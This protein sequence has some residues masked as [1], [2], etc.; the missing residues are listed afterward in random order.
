MG[1][2]GGL[3]HKTGVFQLSDH[4]RV[5]SVVH[6]HV[7]VCRYCTWPTSLT[8]KRATTKKDPRDGG[9]LAPNIP[10]RPH[11]GGGGAFAESKTIGNFPGL[12]NPTYPI[13]HNTYLCFFFFFFFFFFGGGGSPAH[14]SHPSWV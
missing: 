11:G 3:L 10:G 13:V 2:G 8:S 6:V 14:P 9:I 12:K 5:D 4:R 1:G 7:H